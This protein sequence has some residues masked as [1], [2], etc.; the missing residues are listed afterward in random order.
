MQMWSRIEAAALWN[1]I[2]QSQTKQKTRTE[3]ELILYTFMFVHTTQDGG[4]SDDVMGTMM[5]ML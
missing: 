2:K 1:L 4:G 5:R 3:I